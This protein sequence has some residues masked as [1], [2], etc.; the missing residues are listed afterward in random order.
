MKIN[1][2][3]HINSTGLAGLTP[4]RLTT[5]SVSASVPFSFTLTNVWC[6]TLEMM[7]LVDVVILVYSALC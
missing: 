2:R 3:S 7:S 4:N 1:G 5:V 6:M